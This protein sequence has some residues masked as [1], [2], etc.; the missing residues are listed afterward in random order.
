MLFV[1]VVKSG[2]KIIVISKLLILIYTI[3]ICST[4][5]EL[6]S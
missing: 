6:L 5:D 2:N 1:L 4:S 3:E